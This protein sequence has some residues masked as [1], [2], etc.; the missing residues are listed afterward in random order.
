MAGIPINSPQEQYLAHAGFV[1]TPRY[2]DDSRQ[3][4]LEVAPK[5][6][7]VIQ[8]V[9]HIPAR[10]DRLEQRAQNFDRLTR[11]HGAVPPVIDSDNL[12]SRA[13][14]TCLPHDRTLHGHRLGSGP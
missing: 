14:E 1:T 6:V 5:G 8:R 10:D 12:L 7:G 11:R 2:F 3:Q 9:L 13:Y 4:F